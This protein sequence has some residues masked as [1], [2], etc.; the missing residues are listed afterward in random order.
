[1]SGRAIERRKQDYKRGVSC[2]DARRRRTEH[3]VSIRKNKREEGLQKRR[4]LEVIEEP[5]PSDETA[6]APDLQTLKAGLSHAD[7]NVQIQC[8]RGIRKMLSK[9]G[10]PPVKLVMSAGLLPIIVAT[11]SREDSTELMFEAAW[12]VT[13]I[14]STDYTAEVAAHGAIAPLSRL[15]MHK[16]ADL[17]EQ[18]AWCLGNIAGDSPAL[19]D[20]VLD[21]GDAVRG[22]LLN[23]TQAASPSLMRNCVWALSN[24]CR[25]KPHPRAELAAA[26]APV[27]VSVLS[28]SDDEA[29]VDAGWALSYLSD[30]DNDRIEV[31]VDAGALPPLMAMLDSKA[32][33]VVTPALR[34]VGNIVTGSDAATQAAVDHGALPRLVRLLAHTKKGIRKESC[35]A[36]S[37]IA[38]GSTH[39]IAALCACEGALAG[40]VMQ[41]ETGEWDVQKEAAWA[42]SNLCTSGS[43]AQARKVVKLGGIAPMCSLLDKADTNIVI[44][45]LEAIERMLKADDS[46]D[47]ATATRVDECGGMDLIERLQ[48]HDDQRVY[49]KA[50]NILQ[51]YFGGDSEGEEDENFAPNAAEGDATFSFGTPNVVPSGAQRFAF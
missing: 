13:N 36:L 20:L 4:N 29:R 49:E 18:C 23:I 47:Q 41:L 2:E 44:V 34:A 27:A 3:Q 6:A 39:Q 17:R 14:A 48:Y 1:M 11:L 22:L 46:D 30:G 33:A 15:L 40:L 37:N 21:G 16:S 51:T 25:G 43:K 26:A 45:A 31:V 24:F 32:A 50:S 8:M 28:S 19:R 35:W 10:N 38:A 5:G 9:E 42:I 12:A 7:V